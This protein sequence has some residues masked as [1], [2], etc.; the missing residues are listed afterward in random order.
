M[1]YQPKTG[2]RFRKEIAELFS[3][4]IVPGSLTV[5]LLLDDLAACEA[6]LATLQETAAAD[7]KYIAAI[8][9][10][11]RGEEVQCALHVSQPINELRD[12]K[13]ELE[14]MVRELVDIVRELPADEFTELADKAL[15]LLQ[16]EAGKEVGR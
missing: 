4:P 16:P 9:A 3:N 5:P 2:M 11:C 8:P 13:A 1:T 10:L 6:A 12:R 15:A 7:S 14:Q